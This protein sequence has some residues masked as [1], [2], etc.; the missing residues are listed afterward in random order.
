MSDPL[1]STRSRALHRLMA[2]GKRST[3]DN[4][5]GIRSG[6]SAGQ[7]ADLRIDLLFLLTLS[8]PRRCLTPV[9]PPGASRSFSER[10]L[11]RSSLSRTSSPSR[12]R[13]A[14][15]H[16]PLDFRV[17]GGA[18][19]ALGNPPIARV[20]SAFYASARRRFKAR[21]DEPSTSG[22]RSPRFRLRPAAFRSHGGFALSLRDCENLL[23]PYCLSQSIWWVH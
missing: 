2:F 6:D 21:Q 19:H 22:E 14:I 15:A 8:R 16:G 12:R 23:T 11:S 7:S 5:S 9:T 20:R 17:S 10:F 3:G 18:V 4:S 1:S 13:A